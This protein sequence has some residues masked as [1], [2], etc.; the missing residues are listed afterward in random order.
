[1]SVQIIHKITKILQQNYDASSQYYK[2]SSLTY[3]DYPQSYKN[4]SQNCKVEQNYKVKQNDED[5]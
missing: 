5:S 4:Y 2:D 1:M 3:K